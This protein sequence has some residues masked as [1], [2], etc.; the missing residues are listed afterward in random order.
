MLTIIFIFVCSRHNLEKN[1]LESSAHF[2][3]N[4][5]LF[6]LVYSPFQSTAPGFFWEILLY[7]CN[8]SKA[9]V[10]NFFF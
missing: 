5:I 1:R 10:F 8:P 6:S 3:S 9:F 7:F 4:L 2:S